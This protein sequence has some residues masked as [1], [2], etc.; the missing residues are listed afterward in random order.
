MT[1]A[2]LL[3]VF[4]SSFL[5]KS[6]SSES[7]ERALDYSDDFGVDTG[8]W[9]YKGN[10]YRDNVNKYAVLTE[11][12]NA[13]A[14]AIWLNESL[15]S[16]FT[17]RFRYW[18]GNSTGTTTDGFVVM[19]Y[20]ERNFTLL[21]GGYLGFCGPGYGV[22]FDTSRN[23]WD[24]PDDH[25]ALIEDGTSNHLAYVYDARLSD[26]AWHN[27]TITVTMASVVV[28]IDAGK[29]LQWNGTLDIK[30]D[31]FGFSAG[32][33][34]A[35]P[36]GW[37]EWHIIDDFSISARKDFA[38]SDEFSGTVLNPAWIWVDPLMDCNYS[39]TANPG[40]L[41]IFVPGNGHDLY[42][43]ANYNAP[44]VIQSAI[45]DFVIET[46]V[47]FDPQHG[48]QGAGILVWNDSDNYLRLDRLFHIGGQ[49]VDLSGK[50]AGSWSQ[51]A[52]TL[53]VSTET[54]LRLERAGENF[55]AKYSS[56]GIN[57]IFLGSVSFPLADTVGVGLFVL[58]QWQD[59]PIY[60]DFD[61][62][63]VGNPFQLNKLT[64]FTENSIGLPVSNALVQAAN[65]TTY[66]NA[67]GYASFDLPFGT[68]NVTASHPDY[69]SAWWI[70]DLDRDK[71]ITLTLPYPYVFEG[72]I[73]DSNI[74]LAPVQSG[75]NITLLNNLTS[76]D[77]DVFFD[78]K[79]MGTIPPGTWQVFNF[80]HLPNLVV[81]AAS[82]G[83]PDYPN[84][85]YKY[86][87]PIQLTP[88]TGNEGAFPP[89]PTPYVAGSIFIIPY[90]PVYGQDT[91]IGV[92]LHNPYNHTLHISRADFQISGL[93]VGGYFTSV[94]DLS[95]ISLQANETR[96]FSIIWNATV[97]GHHCIRVVLTYS[98]ATQALQRNLD[99]EYEVIQ[100]E[101]GEVSFS[102]VNPFETSKVMTL[103]VNK[104]LSS[105]AT[106]EIDGRVYDTSSDIVI[107]VAPGQELHATLRIQTSNTV[108]EDGVVD[109]EA[110]VDGQLIGGVRK[111]IKTVPI[112]YPQY[113]GYYLA[114]PD[115]TR[116]PDQTANFG[117]PYEIVVLIKNP[118]VVSHEYTI[119]LTQNDVSMPYG[120]ITWNWPD[121]LKTFM[122]YV[123]AP[124]QWNAD[125]QWVG[126]IS[127]TD[128]VAPGQ[129]ASF[130]FTAS[131]KWKWIPPWSEKYL[132]S[133]VIWNI[134]RNVDVGKLK[135]LYVSANR[136]LGYLKT[137]ENAG[138]I[139]L[140][141]RFNFIVSFGSTVLGTGA[142]SVKVSPY[143]P[144]I[145]AYINS[146]ALSYGASTATIMGIGGSVLVIPG[147]LIL[148]EVGMIAA[149]NWQY[150]VAADPSSDYTQVVQ[151]TPPTLL[152]GTEIMELPA[153]KSLT[154]NMYNAIQTLADFLEYQNATTISAERYTTAKAAG[155]QYY[156]NLQLQA[157]TTYA[158]HRDLFLASLE[159][160]LSILSPM[161]P[162][163]N[164]SAIRNA[165][166]YLSQ[167]GLPIEEQQLL[168]GFGLSSSIPD[169]TTGMQVLLNLTLLN[170]TMLSQFSLINGIQA[171]KSLLIEETYSWEQQPSPG[172]QHNV[173]VTSVTP[174][175]KLAYKDW[176]M[177]VNV[178][179]TNLGNFTEIKTLSLYYNGTLGEG[180]I[181]TQIV[182]LAPNQTE[183][184]TFT[185]N[186][187]G[188]VKGNYT[189]WAYA[190]PVQGETDTTDN[191]LVGGWV[192]VTIPGDIDGSFS[193]D[194]GDLGL[195]GL[196]WYS[197]PGQ[198][199]WN[200]NADLNN[201]GLVDGG[202]L[203]ILGFYW[204]Q[205][206]P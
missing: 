130:V 149:Q 150:I 22:E 85:W 101:R 36:G 58:D 136:L 2:L 15:S 83:S 105:E 158:C 107:E 97:G 119:T 68:Y 147:F 78:W 169:I 173:A 202:D 77:M 60:A 53:Y 200:P 17:V 21:K 131:S 52:Q 79:N 71:N 45:G 23:D 90:P 89:E 144:K 132:M 148:L 190:W 62:F 155:D 28:Y 86:P 76:S 98:P 157:V 16:S 194:G 139:I 10:A 43:G 177:N 3:S 198:N 140:T 195:L 94:G 110:Y 184:L 18:V 82:K 31:G 26:S 189:I 126:T 4:A 182:V 117:E 191:K 170:E 115:G 108:P 137:V 171:V 80:D 13:Q 30:Y 32:T 111:T 37:N 35:W 141:E 160:Q 114:Y 5:I 47:L 44:R 161:L 99:V 73:A 192:A 154:E 152:N 151:P 159:N 42:P 199:N 59:N 153:V 120:A 118:D 27:V 167:N 19:F 51:F 104:Q 175:R 92:T 163:L 125:P 67:S 109:I 33:G 95:D 56:D 1:T 93:T 100:G 64:V 156:Q 6:V 197:A 122:A 38:I 138:I 113:L 203:G 54:Y 84:A 74:I 25:V 183:T 116:I 7:G 70:V 187:T 143:N 72:E 39:L 181:E 129:N 146:L 40:Y 135:E 128:T 57:W 66:S 50:K 123:G 11:A 188:F 127:V 61:Y 201:D 206:G 180:T 186:T 29:I 204:F 103:K 48:A 174:Y 34:E 24:P 41:R 87:L 20:K 124:S 63:R 106:L 205:T 179:A 168:E 185:W 102:L 165:Q 121:W 81:E 8:L 145:N 193:V 55:T 46:R 96:I 134:L 75:Y 196:A 172:L 65:I 9:T 12:V 164:S 88:T 91:T 49:V 112:T 69:Q 133:S 14:G 142:A 176:C 162:P 166:N 178:T